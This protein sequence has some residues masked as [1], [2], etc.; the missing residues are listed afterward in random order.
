MGNISETNGQS[1]NTSL[2]NGDENR[3]ASPRTGKPT[4]SGARTGSGT[5]T[6]IDSGKQPRTASQAKQAASAK[7]AGG[8]QTPETSIG[9]DPETPPTDS[10]RAFSEAVTPPDRPKSR[11]RKSKPAAQ[12][13]T[14]DQAVEAVHA[15]IE[16]VQIFAVSKFGADG[17]FNLTE[18]ALI[19]PSLVRLFERYGSVAQQY[20]W[21]LDPLLV[22]AGVTMYGIRLASVA[23]PQSGDAP[24]NGQGGQK[25][26]EPPATPNGSNGATAGLSPTEVWG[27]AGDL[28]SRR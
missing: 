12:H 21:I 27:L 7:K 5:R 6:G 25:A 1:G 24:D 19:E 15:L 8:G 26:P 28:H 2:G 20:S 3:D 14:P 11:G 9:V 18:L 4:G 10:Q 16:M 22:A 13:P 23:K 17:A